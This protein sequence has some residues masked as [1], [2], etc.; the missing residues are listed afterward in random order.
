VNSPVNCTATAKISGT[1]ARMEIWVDGVKK[2]SE[3]T[4]LHESTSIALPAGKHK[5]TFNAVNTA[6]T[7]W[8]TSV[9]ATV[10]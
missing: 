1:L 10:Q 3:S 8:A 7:K 9:F 2:Y 5:F 4:S 6:G